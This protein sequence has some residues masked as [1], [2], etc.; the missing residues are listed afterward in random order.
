[1]PPKVEKKAKI[2]AAPLPAPM[3][4]E[5]DVPTPEPELAVQTTNTPPVTAV[6][7]VEDTASTDLLAN[8]QESMTLLALDT[9]GEQ[10]VSVLDI[11]KKLLNDYKLLQKQ[12]K[13]DLKN[14]QSKKLRKAASKTT[15]GGVTKT[16]GFAKPGFISAH[17]CEFLGVPLGTELART[18]V[19]K[20]I[21]QYIKANN[22]QDAKN[23]RVIVMDPSLQSLLKPEKDQEVTY[24]NLQ[25][26][27]K[28]HYVK[29]ATVTV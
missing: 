8:T 15:N 26:F 10:I 20:K 19:T 5:V 6:V 14:A 27:M 2:A 7:V 25:S 1:M 3:T 12:L 23:K 22:L 4:I 21:T 13:K 24:F 18:D 29:A 11:V 17:L 9:L 28:R 16:S